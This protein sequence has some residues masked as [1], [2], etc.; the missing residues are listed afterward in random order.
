MSETSASDQIHPASPYRREQAIRDGDGAR[1]FELSAAIQALAAIG[2]GFLFLG[3]L[4]QWVG[5]WT[6]DTWS[7][8]ARNISFEP[9]A[10]TQQLRD[11]AFAGSLAMAP[12]LIAMFA[13]GVL[14]HMSQCGVRLR[15]NRVLPELGRIAPQK[16]W[17]HVFSMHAISL[18]F[19]SLPKTVVA[20]ATA[21]VNFW[22]QKEA[23]FGLGN[24]PVEQIGREMYSL[25]LGV[26]FHVAVVL[27]ALSLVDYGLQRWSFERRIRM[28]DQQVRDEARMQNGDPQVLHQYRALHRSLGRSSNRT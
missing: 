7:N 11:T 21:V 17:Q 5:D 14:A 24:L 20:F 12:I 28:T 18:P 16:W 13:A 8:A 22:M 19:V 1:S 23:F 3:G 10:A 15:T 6:R 9:T 26:C 2:V 4:A 25:V 27:F